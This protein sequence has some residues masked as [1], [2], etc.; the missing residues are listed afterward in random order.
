MN[1]WG[2]DNSYRRHEY[3]PT[4]KMNQALTVKKNGKN[5]P[6]KVK[7]IGDHMIDVSANGKTYTCSYSGRHWVVQG[8]N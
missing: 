3:S 2:Y 7:T 6:A 5:M 4:V 1:E 8:L